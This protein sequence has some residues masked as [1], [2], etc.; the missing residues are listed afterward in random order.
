MHVNVA[1]IGMD[2]LG[3]S[4]GLALKRYQS[5]SKGQHTFTIIGSDPRAQPMKDANKMGAIDNFNRAVLKATANAD[6]LIVN[7]PFGAT[8]ELYAQFG[9]D[10]K[11]GAVVLDTSLLKV[12]VF[13]YTKEFFPKDPQGNPVAYVVGITPIVNAK[14]LYSGDLEVEGARA[15]LF[16]EAEV[17]VTPD[18]GT[19]SEAIQLAEDLIGLIGGKA[20]FMDPAEHDGLI[21]ATEILPSLLGTATF[22]M[23]TQSEGWKEFRRMINPTMALTMQGLRTQRADDINGLLK[24]N[25][26]NVARHLDSLIDVLQQLREA[27]A[28]DDEDTIEA[29]TSKALSEWDKWDVK[30]FSGQW[31]EGRAAVDSVAGPLGSLGGMLG[32]RRRRRDND[33]DED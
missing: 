11:R 26:A 21:A 15:D 5:T 8:E 22:Y 19:P 33:E 32:M 2:R 13:G 1:I 9:P 7:A 25:S 29:F 14:A 6:L 4:F 3:A 23:L 28:D 20:R 17:L 24:R 18:I 31:E 10:L 12:P 27:L 30:R 16:D